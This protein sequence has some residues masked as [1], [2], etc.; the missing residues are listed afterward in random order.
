MS[1]LEWKKFV[2]EVCPLGKHKPDCIVF[3][4]YPSSEERECEMGQDILVYMIDEQTI[5]LMIT[6]G[7]QDAPSSPLNKPI[8]KT[9]FYTDRIR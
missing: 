4:C 6:F 5:K 2:K 3:A 9:N 7:S 8:D 1:G